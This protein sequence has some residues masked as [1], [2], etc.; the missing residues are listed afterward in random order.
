MLQD[1]KQVKKNSGV[2]WQWSQIADELSVRHELLTKTML[3]PGKGNRLKYYKKVVPLYTKTVKSP[4]PEFIEV[5]F[6]EYY[7]HK[8]SKKPEALSNFIDTNL[9]M[10]EKAAEW[11]E[12]CE[13]L[14]EQLGV[15]RLHW[16]AGCMEYERARMNDDHQN[17]HNIK[18]AL[19]HIQVAS[20][21][22]SEE[23]EAYWSYQAK[24]AITML[25]FLFNA[26]EPLERQNNK[27]IRSTLVK[28]HF[29]KVIRNVLV[30]D[31][32]NIIVIR[33]GLVAASALNNVP[34][35]LHIGRLLF[36]ADSRFKDP[37]FNMMGQ[38]KSFKEDSDLALFYERVYPVLIF[39]HCLQSQMEP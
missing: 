10:I 34:H 39:E 16:L 11:G 32:K 2:G 12:K 28:N 18:N 9:G 17:L 33:N 6:H 15:C 38:M 7:Q 20:D 14:S 30:V 4:F 13:K 25:A 24:L 1:I 5:K 27:E 19:N 22:L 3:K 21:I 31:P 36:K 37:D 23:G 26:V 8:L 29:F 35:M